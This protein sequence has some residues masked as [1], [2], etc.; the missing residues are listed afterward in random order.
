MPKNH[1]SVY[2]ENETRE[3]ASAAGSASEHIAAMHLRAA[4]KWGELA[5]RQEKIE[6]GS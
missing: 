5:E 2:R 3:R 1:S 6:R 4:A